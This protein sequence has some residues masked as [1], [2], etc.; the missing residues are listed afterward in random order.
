VV[1][2]AVAAGYSVIMTADHG[3]CDEMIDPV[4]GD[5]HTQHTIY[6]VPCVVIDPQP[7]HLRTG[8]G[9]ANIAATVLELMGLPVPK[10]MK[11]SLLLDAIKRPA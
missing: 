3:N 6:P 2:A 1:D 8:G 4:T 11:T 10:K 5:P 7:R 9:I